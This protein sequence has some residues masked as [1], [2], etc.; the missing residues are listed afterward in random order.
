[1]VDPEHPVEPE[2]IRLVRRDATQKL[3]V[4]YDPKMVDKIAGCIVDHVRRGTVGEGITYADLVKR[5][6]VPSWV[7][8]RGLLGH[9]LALVALQSYERDR[10]FL[11]AL[12]RA[13]VDDVP[14]TRGFCKFLEDVGSVVSRTARDDCLELWDHH[15]KMAI[16]HYDSVARRTS[17]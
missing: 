17:S 13:R 10:F 9:V 6:R 2:R 5:A 4:I 15:W 1:M 16:T 7:G 12:A 11:S 8:H 14:P 3:G